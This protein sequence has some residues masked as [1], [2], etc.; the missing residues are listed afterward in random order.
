MVGPALAWT[1][2]R[3]AFNCA[4]AHDE[5]ALFARPGCEIPLLWSRVH[6]VLKTP[7]ALPEITKRL[8][9]N[10]LMERTQDIQLVVVETIPSEGKKP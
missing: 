3:V 9:W 10:S 2:R 7:H 1:S 6:D 4:P 5:E 8:V